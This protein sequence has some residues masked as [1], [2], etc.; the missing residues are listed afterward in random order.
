MTVQDCWYRYRPSNPLDPSCPL[1][2]TCIRENVFGKYPGLDQRGRHSTAN[3]DVEQRFPGAVF[4]GNDRYQPFAAY[5]SYIYFD[6]RV[7]LIEQLQIFRV[8][9]DA[10][11]G[12]PVELSLFFCLFD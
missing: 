7:F 8:I 9:H 2:N 11:A 5:A 4:R 12:V 10:H 1:K 3:D 6:E